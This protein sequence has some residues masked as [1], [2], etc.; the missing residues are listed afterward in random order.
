MMAETWFTIQQNQIKVVINY[1]QYHPSSYTRTHAR[2]FHGRTNGMHDVYEI[3]L[4]GSR[5]MLSWI[6]KTK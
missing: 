3:T 2:T 4:G 6:K 5:D 1:S